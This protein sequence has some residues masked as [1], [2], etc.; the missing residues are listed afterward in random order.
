MQHDFN[1]NSKFQP[2]L[3]RVFVFVLDENDSRCVVVTVAVTVG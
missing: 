3:I 1:M 2:F